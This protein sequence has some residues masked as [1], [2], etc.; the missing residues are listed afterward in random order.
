MAATK[1]NEQNQNR[2]AVWLLFV[3]AIVICL[4]A[5]FWH[6]WPPRDASFYYLRM[7][8]EFKEGNWSGVWYPM[9]PPLYIAVTG[10]VSTVLFLPVMFAGKLVSI[11]FFAGTVFPLSRILTPVY[12]RRT[13]QI[14]CLLLVFCSR[15]IRDSAAPLLDSGKMFFLLWC[16]CLNIEAFRRPAS[17]SRA[18]IMGTAAAGLALIRGEGVILAILAII[19]FAVAEIWH[20]HRESSQKSLFFRLPVRSAAGFALFLLLLLP[21][22]LYMQ[23]QTGYPVLDSRQLEVLK[24]VP[25]T[26]LMDRRQLEPASKPL[27]AGI[28]ALDIA[29]QP[30]VAADSESWT[31]E[32]TSSVAVIFQTISAKLAPELY[33]GVHQYY[34]PLY[35]AGIFILIKRRQWSRYDWILPAVFVA[36]T[37]IVLLAVGRLWT[38]A[39]YILPAAPLLFGWAAVGG[40]EIVGWSKKIIPGRQNI[41][42][43]VILGILAL[44]MVFNG[45]LRAYHYLRKSRPNGEY[46]APLAAA[47]WLREEGEENTLVDRLPLQSTDRHYHSHRR[48][49]L[50]SVNRRIPFLGEADAVFADLYTRSLT[51]SETIELS[52]EKTVDFIVVDQTW[53][54][55]YGIEAED[56]A[57][58]DAIKLLKKFGRGIHRVEVL[59][60]LP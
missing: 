53:R 23:N 59:K 7:V 56:I 13:A 38:Q 14:G 41:I 55:K 45:N 33:K 37:L 18:L 11:L 28:G 22:A 40:R 6:N 12:G 54:E 50:L 25:L 16:V 8:R 26:E 4:P 19:A 46:A 31:T 44:I 30:A 17:L 35:L 60:V 5:L 57:E 43:G 10:V 27:L 48:P 3:L 29:A 42:I 49:L 15:L 52:R 21:W 2:N 47:E 20:R 39:R 51:V 9:I 36:H 1:S 34:I 24:R 58:D 32:V